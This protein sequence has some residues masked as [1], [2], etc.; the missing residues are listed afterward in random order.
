MSESTLDKFARE[1]QEEILED[2]RRNYSETVVDH[3]MQP[4]HLGFLPQHNGYGRLTGSCGDT[5][6]FFLDIENERITR[7][8]FDTDGCGTSIASASITAELALGKPLKEAKMIT[9]LTVL[10]KAG[11]LPEEDQ[12][13]ALLAAN[14]LQ[15]AIKNYEERSK[16]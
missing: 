4:R 11:G 16:G 13:C 6:E 10:E 15:E 12:H 2:V 1:L 8:G 7:I 5:M 9:N 3:W 14:T